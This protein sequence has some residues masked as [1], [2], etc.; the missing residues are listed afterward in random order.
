MATSTGSG[1]FSAVVGNLVNGNNFVIQ[2]GHNVTLDVDL[3]GL[4]TGLGASTVNGVLD[5]KADAITGLNMNGAIG[6][7]GAIYLA[8]RAIVS[9]FTL[10]NGKT[11]VYEVAR[12]LKVGTVEETLGNGFKNA[13]SEMADLALGIVNARLKELNQS[14]LLPDDA[15]EFRITY[16]A[17]LTNS[18][19][20]DYMELNAST[21]YH[22]TTNNKLYIHTSDDSNPSSKTITVIEPIQ[23]PPVGTESR[24]NI[25]INSTDI[26]TVPIYKEYA[27]VPEREFAQLAS[28]VALNATQI[29][30]TH[31]L[32][33][34][35]GD[36]IAI[37]SGTENA[38]KTAE[39]QKHL[40][41][42]QSYDANTKIAT[43]TSG[44]GTARLAGDYVSWLSRPIKRTRSSGGTS[45]VQAD[46]VVSYGVYS[47]AQ[48]LGLS[49]DF[50]HYLVN[51]DIRHC[52]SYSN[53]F[54]FTRYL[55]SGKIRDSL[56]AYVSFL[57]FGCSNMDIQRVVGLSIV[58][59]AAWDENLF[60]NCVFQNGQYAGGNG[61]INSRYKNCVTKNIGMLT[62]AS[63]IFYENCVFSGEET[64]EVDTIFEAHFKD[65][66]FKNN[67]SGWL[68]YAYGKLD[69]CLFE[70][71]EV[72]QHQLIN[73]P[74][75]R[76]IESFNH[77]Q[78]QDN[79][80]AW[81]AGGRI[82]TPYLSLT[83]QLPSCEAWR[84]KY[85]FKFI[86]ESN[87][88]PV[89]KDYNVMVPA[90]RTM[91]F[92][93]KVKK[94]TPGA[95]AKIQ[96]IDPFNDPLIDNT[97]IPL[98]ETVSQNNTAN[99]SISVA[100]ESDR[101]REVILRILCQNSTGNVVI[102]TSG[103]DTALSK[104]LNY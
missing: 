2:A 64:W 42:I 75:Y 58:G 93:I 23:R 97:C 38:K 94:D 39:T 73:R 82:E 65:C 91:R 49:V 96:I 29:P 5:V 14:E 70:G 98:L 90:N 59:G 31:D 60:N 66:V 88:K 95:I 63:T 79:Y 87:L 71:S 89:V 27:W 3:S 30:I 28:D 4:T 34:Q 24:C 103:I 57:T 45:I 102:D 15:K 83:E 100:Y 37:G 25:K 55:K 84:M 47:N 9:G 6:G 21:F 78:I 40:Y 86:C 32:G 56:A 61:G 26:I 67:V 76:R 50:M 80:K 62:Y 33:L 18:D 20:L 99:Q 7:S 77:N 81:M 68:N 22:D 36:K 85:I 41:T 51:C 53:S 10:T 13:V 48:F 54:Y 19:I 1:L 12:T 104:P 74:Q 52:T 17:N 35:A 16:K 69:N 44:I 8:N 11:K 72:T 43:L 92:P 101:P 46:N